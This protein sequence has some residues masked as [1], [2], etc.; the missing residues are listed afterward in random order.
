MEL[1]RLLIEPSMYRHPP[2]KDPTLYDHTRF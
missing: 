1:P 2:E